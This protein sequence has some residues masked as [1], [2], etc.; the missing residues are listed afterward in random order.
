MQRF[1][2][3]W[4]IV[5]RDLYNLYIYI[6]WQPKLW[7]SSN[8]YLIIFIGNEVITSWRDVF[9]TLWRKYGVYKA[10]VISAQ[11]DYRCMMKYMPFD[12]RDDDYGEV[13]KLCPDYFKENSTSRVH[14]PKG[15]RLFE[16][17][18]N[19]RDYPI[20]VIAFE[21]LFMNVTYD[22][23]NRLKLS[24]LDA[25]VLYT[26]EKVLKAKFRITAMR[27]RDFGPEDPFSA[28][29]RSIERGTVE[30]VITGFFVK[31]YSKFREFQL[32]SA[33]YEDK[34]CFLSP[35]SGLVPKAYMPFMPFRK[36][37]WLV[38]VL[39]NI[40]ISFLWCL[41]GYLNE[42]LLRYESTSD[43]I[44]NASE[45]IDP[46][47]PGSS[48]ESP[49]NLDSHSKSLKPPEIH[50]CLSSIF[51][52]L[53]TL[54]YPFQ[55]GSSI[56]QNCLL[57][58]SLF[59]SLIVN[60]VYESCLVSSL[61]KPFHYPQLRTLEDVVDSGKP[62]ITK[63]ANLKNVFV[64]E[65]PLDR[66]LIQRI[67]VIRSNRS[68]KDIVVFDKKISITRYY[69]MKLGNFSYFDK[70]GNDMLHVVDECPMNYRVA[71]VLRSNSP[72]RERVDFVLLRSREAGL[73]TFWFNRMLYPLELAKLR[74]KLEMEKGK[75]R[76][77]LDHYS[78]TIVVLFG[79]LFCSGLIFLGEVY[80]GRHYMSQRTS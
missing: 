13:G 11:D 4:V 23:Q 35:D 25:K 2:L 38:L 68:T 24:N 72:Y 34:V 79:G 15:R 52:F 73:L 19:L 30:M 39:Y 45:L 56:T 44:D 37:V 66:Q 6:Y 60:G 17:F 74:R 41:T 8:R 16:N 26:L 63:Y 33:V 58:A 5:V 67:H 3:T 46:S 80:A 40:G 1:S 47:V 50:S 57:S 7:T 59:F 61:N 77:T 12:K 43:T 14:R 29:L 69:T 53:E 20:N 36:E 55:K 28:S 62:V 9:A 22:T 51:D 75:V 10:V 64:D 54:C 76:L 18:Q 49:R 27:K 70:D 48:K 31:V 21:S 32:T 65:S 78:L 42:L 71:Y